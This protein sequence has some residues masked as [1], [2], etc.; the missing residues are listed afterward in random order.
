MKIGAHLENDMF[1]EP[2][3]RTTKTYGLS[4]P[5]LIT[6]VILV[7]EGLAYLYFIQKIVQTISE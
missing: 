5:T 1:P 4:L 6:I 3:Q 7:T 2:N